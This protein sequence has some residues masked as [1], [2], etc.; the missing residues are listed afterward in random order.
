M[1]EKNNPEKSSEEAEKASFFNKGAKEESPQKKSNRKIYQRLWNYFDHR[2]VVCTKEARI[3]LFGHI[4]QGS[5]IQP[6]KEYYIAHAK[7]ITFVT[8]IVGRYALGDKTDE[9]I[10]RF[11]LDR[12]VAE[13]FA[14]AGL[15]KNLIQIEEEEVQSILSKKSRE[16]I[17]NPGITKLSKKLK[18]KEAALAPNK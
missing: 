18:E 7:S 12:Q 1:K 10:R 13:R 2:N 11:E 4:L 15:L 16:T 8:E 5:D 17:I 14:R 9:A 3:I 6:V